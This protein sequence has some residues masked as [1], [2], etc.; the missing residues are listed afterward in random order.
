MTTVLAVWRGDLSQSVTVGAVGFEAV[1][2]VAQRAGNVECKDEKRGNVRGWRF[3]D[4]EG[5]GG[6]CVKESEAPAAVA[7]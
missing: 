4:D 3:K 6:A 1:D 7:A 2:R 5:G